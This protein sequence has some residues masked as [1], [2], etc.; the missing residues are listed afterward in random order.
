MPRS[1]MLPRVPSACTKWVSA[2][3]DAAVE[4]GLEDV[5][6]IARLGIA[7]LPELVDELLPLGAAGQARPGVL[8]LRR[9]DPLDG[10]VAPLLVDLL[11]GVGRKLEF[12]EG[13]KDRGPAVGVD[14]R[15]GV[16]ARG[17]EGR[18]GLLR[19]H[20]GI[21]RRV[22]LKVQEDLE[23]RLRLLGHA[24]V[25][26]AHAAVEGHRGLE[27]RRAV[28]LPGLADSAS[29]SVERLHGLLPGFALDLGLG[30][31][32]ELGKG[33][34]GERNGEKESKRRDNGESLHGGLRRR[35][36]RPAR[37]VRRSRS[38]LLNGR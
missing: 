31:L 1:V 21:H 4:A 36:L 32:E 14:R 23:V 5:V 27:L 6:G 18:D 30:L 17:F 28:S 8:L 2:N 25:G 20:R 3:A 38:S 29:S 11:A 19:V 7:G 12:L 37:S 22:R 13:E 9:H 24:E 16:L 26:F 35:I 15:G 10:T 33:L 34:R